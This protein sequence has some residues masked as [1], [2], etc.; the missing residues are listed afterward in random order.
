MIY[1]MG[2]SVNSHPP[3]WPSPA[4]LRA[5]TRRLTQRTSSE[6]RHNLQMQAPFLNAKAS[7]RAVR[8]AF[9]PPAQ[10]GGAPLF[11][12]TV[13]WEAFAFTNGACICK[14]CLPSLGVLWVCLLITARRSA[15]GRGGARPGRRAGIYRWSPFV[16]H[17]LG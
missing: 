13:L 10:R 8:A 1:K 4:D 16:N 9:G 17:C 7:Q 14:L 6:G 12:D 11:V 15:G 5:L 3:P 2:P